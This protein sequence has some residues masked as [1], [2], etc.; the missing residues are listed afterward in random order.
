MSLLWYDQEFFGDR[1]REF[2]PSMML[3]EASLPLVG[4]GAAAHPGFQE[5]ANSRPFPASRLQVLLKEA[6]H[7]LRLP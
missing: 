2:Q 5:M 3:N 7:C 6:L 1:Q 4:D